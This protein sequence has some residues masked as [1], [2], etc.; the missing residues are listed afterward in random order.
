MQFWNIYRDIF[1]FRL[2]KYFKLREMKYFDIII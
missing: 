2:K 1:D